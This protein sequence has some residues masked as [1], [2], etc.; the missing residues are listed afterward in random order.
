MAPHD[1]WARQRRTSRGSSHNTASLFP[2]L[3]RVGYDACALSKDRHAR[4]ADTPCSV[5][6]YQ[7]NRYRILA[8]D[9]SET[10]Q[11][12]GGG[13]V[14]LRARTGRSEPRCR[15]SAI[16]QLQ[17]G[18]GA[19]GRRQVSADCGSPRLASSRA[20][21]LRARARRSKPRTTGLL[22]RVGD[23]DV[24][25]YKSLQDSTALAIYPHWVPMLLR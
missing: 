3:E 7:L 15:G 24:L 23:N 12:L 9:G 19:R 8:N 4:T 17:G 20:S 13:A 2:P 6:S 22:T 10:E 16:L 11:L 14:E 18:A 25:T 5:L 21:E 1:C